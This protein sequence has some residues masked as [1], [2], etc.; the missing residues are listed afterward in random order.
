ME[1]VSIQSSFHTRT[2]KFRLGTGS[3][4]ENAISN[5]YVEGTGGAIIGSFV[6]VES[7]KIADRPELLKA[8]SSG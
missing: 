3:A 6:E 2:V 4:Q 8:L 5:S 7:G 1:F